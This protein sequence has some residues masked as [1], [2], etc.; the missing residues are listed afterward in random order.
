MPRVPFSHALRLQHKPP[1]LRIHNIEHRFSAVKPGRKGSVQ[2]IIYILHIQAA[3]L[4]PVSHNRASNGI[5]PGSHMVYIRIRECQTVYH[6]PLRKSQ[7]FH[8]K[9]LSGAGNPH[10]LSGPDKRYLHNGLIFLPSANISFRVLRHGYLFGHQLLEFHILI[11]HGLYGT[12]DQ[13]QT[14]AQILN[15]RCGHLL[16]NLMCH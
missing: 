7:F 3:D 16:R 14:F 8:I 1:R 13:I 15:G 5:G 6:T 9:T 10:T 12:F 4:L 2:R 11:Q